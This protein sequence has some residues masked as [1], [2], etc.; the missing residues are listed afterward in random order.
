MSGAS[1]TV[2]ALAAAQLAVPRE[3]ITTHI[4]EACLRR[5][6]AAAA[7]FAGSTIGRIGLRL[8][9]RLV[10]PGITGHYAWRKQRIQAWAEQAVATGATQV[11]IL[12]AGFDA[13]GQQLALAY[14]QLR[15]FELDREAVVT[16][17]WHA[18]R[19]LGLDLSSQ[20]FIA[21][22]LARGVDAAA[23]DVV[24]GFD[25]AARTLVVAEGVLM[26]LSPRRA[27]VVALQLRRLLTGHVDLV[28]TSMSIRRDGS[29]GFERQS[30]LVDGWLSRG[31]ERFRWGMAGDELASGLVASGLTGVEVA[32]PLE[33]G[34][35][36]P[37]P[38]EL[39]WRGAFR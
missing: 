1:G 15:V 4:A 19:D 25:P 28:G 10:L 21:C 11:V 9:E 33:P 16:T 12:G 2:L 35:P 7:T 23:L 3:R 8:L 27:S 34:D 30:R 18:L 37:C 17:K 24:P 14:P 22:D 13:L 26:Y 6:R 5:S 32:D 29:P 31:N 36:D 39:L 38:G 20:R